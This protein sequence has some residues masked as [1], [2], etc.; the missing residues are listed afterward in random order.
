MVY[1]PQ[2]IALYPLT[3]KTTGHEYHKSGVWNATYLSTNER[4]QQSGEKARYGDL[5]ETLS[6]DETLKSRT[7]LN[8][9]LTDIFDLDEEHV[10]KE[11]ITTGDILASTRTR[12][13]VANVHRESGISI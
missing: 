6:F 10:G 9:Q 13:T 1:V 12:Q 8:R 2:I 4:Y 5:G 11:H 7:D 3:K